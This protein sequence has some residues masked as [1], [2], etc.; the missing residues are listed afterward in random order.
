[1]NVLDRRLKFCNARFHTV[2]CAAAGCA[3]QGYSFEAGD[4]FF[5]LN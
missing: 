2:R 1:L 5:R 4:T 3:L